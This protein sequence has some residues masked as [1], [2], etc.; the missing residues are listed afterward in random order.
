MTRIFDGGFIRAP[1]FVRACHLRV[2][3]R[4]NQRADETERNECDARPP[5][6]NPW[7]RQ[8]SRAKEADTADNQCRGGRDQPGE[9]CEYIVHGS[10]ICMMPTSNYRMQLGRCGASPRLSQYTIQ[11]YQFSVMASVPSRS[12]VPAASVKRP[13]FGCGCRG[14]MN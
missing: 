9:R 1:V 8:T 6:T 13:A 2:Q 3:H 11:G 5:Q 4:P 14:I 12:A 10:K 7:I